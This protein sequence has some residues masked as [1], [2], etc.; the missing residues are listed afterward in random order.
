MNLVFLLDEYGSMS[1][2]IDD[3]I[4]SFNSFVSDQSQDSSLSLY[5]FNDTLTC[6]YKNKPIK[7]VKPLTRSDYKPSGMTALYDA[8]GQVLKDHKDQDGIFV[9]MTDGEENTSRKVSR[10]HIKDLISFSKMNIIFAG[11]NIDDAIEMGISTTMYYDGNCTPDIMK[12][13]S[14]EV[15]RIASSQASAPSS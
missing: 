7:D 11:V 3:A 15:S 4:G 5:T 2:R 12:S 6:V 8:I 10:N 13:L 14:I 1:T 9:I